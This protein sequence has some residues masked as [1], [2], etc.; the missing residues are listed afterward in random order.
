MTT[1]WK[2]RKR[3]TPP[4]WTFVSVLARVHGGVYRQRMRDGE[5]EDGL[6]CD[7]GTGRDD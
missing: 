2:S 1:Q 6:W 7:K 5:T 4:Q 3:S